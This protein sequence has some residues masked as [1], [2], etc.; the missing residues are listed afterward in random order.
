MLLDFALRSAIKRVQVNMD[1]WKL[2]RNYTSAGGLRWWW[3]Y[4]GRSIHTI[5]N[6]KENFLGAGKEIVLEVNAENTKYMVMSLD[7]N[8]GRSQYVQIDDSSFEMVGD[9]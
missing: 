5:E 9:F 1:G 8:T 7:Q 6:K 2:Y 4:N 3:W